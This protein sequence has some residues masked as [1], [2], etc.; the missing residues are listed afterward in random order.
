[1]KER[2]AEKKAVDFLREMGVGM[3]VK[4]MSQAGL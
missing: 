3:P 4:E 1:M 2:F